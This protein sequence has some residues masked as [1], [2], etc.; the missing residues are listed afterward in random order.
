MKYIS[1]LAALFSAACITV[2]HAQPAEV[3]DLSATPSGPLVQTP[4]TL[5][6]PVSVVQ[7]TSSMIVEEAAPSSGDL[8]FQMQT[9]QREVMAL[10]NV[11]ELQTKQIQEL[12]QLSLQRYIEIDRRLASGAQALPVADDAAVDANLSESTV[13]LT[14]G[15]SVD[16]IPAMPE[17]SD[18]EAYDE[19]YQLVKSRQYQDAIPLFEQFVTAYPESVRQANAYYWLGSLY[20]VV[21]QLPMA[22]QRLTELLSRFPEHAK[23]PD[24]SYKLATLYFKLG[25]R[26]ES[27]QMLESVIAKYAT[28]HSNTV[29]LASAFL[30][31]NF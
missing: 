3:V 1:P 19:A 20:M 24:A 26:E 14:A 28:S 18:I 8:Y 17:K 30:S 5:E 9:L 25:K 4:I 21:D 22:E 27:R 13:D 16:V 23:I 2:A 10:R 6:Q 15:V 12:R 7:D 29:K 11:V 31:D